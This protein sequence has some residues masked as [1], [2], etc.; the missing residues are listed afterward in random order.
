MSW[1]EK[2]WSYTWITGM[3]ERFGIFSERF[4]P[5]EET[6]KTNSGEIEH[7]IYLYGWHVPCIVNCTLGAEKLKTIARLF[8][9]KIEHRFCGS[10]NPIICYDYRSG[11]A[12]L[13]EEEI[14]QRNLVNEVKAVIKDENSEYR[15]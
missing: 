13:T 9:V 11:K 8:G 2:D 10:Y 4:D 7:Y 6:T 1:D 12:V 5:F 14:A 15:I 3:P